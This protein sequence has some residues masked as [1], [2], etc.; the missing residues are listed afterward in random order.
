MEFLSPKTKAHIDQ[1]EKENMELR[2]KTKELAASNGPK[3]SVLWMVLALVSLA[4]ALFLWWNQTYVLKQ[5]SAEISVQMW[6]AGTVTDTVFT[7][8][9]KLEYSVQVGAFKSLDLKSLS[10]GFKEAS[11]VRNDS[12]TALVVGN[13]T[14]LPKAQELLDVLVSLGM[15]N[16]YIVAHKDGKNVG[17]LSNE[18]TN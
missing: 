2:E 6:S 18:T 16:A 8:N 14:S 13:Y 1:L 3:S 17:L 10:L 12:L 9:D 11:V 4:A 7:P 15:E 5:K